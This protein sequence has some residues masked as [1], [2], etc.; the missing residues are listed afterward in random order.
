MTLL[1]TMITAHVINCWW[2][3]VVT[4]RLSDCVNEFKVPFVILSSMTYA[5]PRNSVLMSGDL[6]AT[7]YLT[8]ALPGRSLIKRVWVSA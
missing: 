1:M 2:T 3:L 6:F 5:F 4:G 7:S 8:L